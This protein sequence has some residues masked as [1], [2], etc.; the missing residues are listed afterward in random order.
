MEL[1][2]HDEAGEGMEEIHI[3]ELNEVADIVYLIV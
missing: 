3:V 2:V 1:C